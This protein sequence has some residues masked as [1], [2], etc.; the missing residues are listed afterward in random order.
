MCYNGEIT[1]HQSAKFL[2]NARK[3]K[4]WNRHKLKHLIIQYENNN[5]K[6]NY[7]TIKTAT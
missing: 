2:K 3:G 5:Y 7:N 4:E 6:N 1:I